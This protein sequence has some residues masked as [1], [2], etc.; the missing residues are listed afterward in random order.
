MSYPF[1]AAVMWQYHEG[2]RDCD[3]FQPV[4]LEELGFH[5]PPNPARS[6]IAAGTDCLVLLF[7]INGVQN[8]HQRRWTN[9]IHALHR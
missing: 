6:S 9:R 2:N 5:Q 4:Y 7:S 3:P 1:L 8:R